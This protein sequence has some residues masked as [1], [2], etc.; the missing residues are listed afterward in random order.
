MKGYSKERAWINKK[1]N[2]G[3]T[4]ERLF[5]TVGIF[6]NKSKEK[7]MR[8]KGL[9]EKQYSQRYNFLYNVFNLLDKDL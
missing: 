2:S 5:N 9:T 7:V 3:V 8:E 6:S 1:L 4:K